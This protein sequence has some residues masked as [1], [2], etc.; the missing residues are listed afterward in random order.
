MP[1]GKSSI[2]R[3]AAGLENPDA[4]PMNLETP[5]VSEVTVALEKKIVES[6]AAT[7]PEK[8]EETVATKIEKKTVKST[9]KKPTAK[10]PVEKKAAEK[11]IEKKPVEKKPAAKKPTAKKAVEEAKAPELIGQAVAAP[12]AKKRGRKPGSK[13]KAKTVK[14][15]AVA[16]VA[17][18]KA[19]AANDSFAAVA[20]GQ[21][22]PVHLL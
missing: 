2:N 1:I 12:A 19:P 21:K 22:L 17:P 20:I 15:P 11:K 7:A 5:A 6:T 18:V 4:A 10:K 3:V 8:G 16:A 14:I 9:A 13:N